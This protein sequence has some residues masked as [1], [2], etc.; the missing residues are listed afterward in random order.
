MKIV[1][2]SSLGCP[3]CIIMNNILNKLKKDYSF[4]YEEYDFDFDDIKK[5]NVGKILPVFIFY[6]N[7]I[8]ITRLCGEHKIQEFIELIEGENK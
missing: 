2:I 4:D 5:F 3:S 8:E 1:Q 7:D 6:K